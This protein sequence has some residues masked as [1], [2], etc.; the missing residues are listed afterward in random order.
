M[1]ITFVSRKAQILNPL[2]KN[3]RNQNANKVHESWTGKTIRLPQLGYFMSY[4]SGNVSY[5]NVVLFCF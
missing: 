3:G 5:T 2:R 1:Q 4:Y